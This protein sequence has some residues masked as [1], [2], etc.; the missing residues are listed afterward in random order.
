MFLLIFYSLILYSCTLV[1]LYTCTLALLYYCT[2][3]LNVQPHASCKHLNIHTNHD[4]VTKTLVYPQI[5]HCKNHRSHSEYLLR[6]PVRAA[7]LSYSRQK[8]TQNCEY[9]WL[10][11][12]LRS[13]ASRN[14]FQICSNSTPD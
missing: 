5:E 8:A 4:L 14:L 9:F 10:C 11:S 2:L 3:V 12:T 1:L 13:E 7:L 6:N